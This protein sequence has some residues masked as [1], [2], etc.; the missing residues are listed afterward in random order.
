MLIDGNNAWDETHGENRKNNATQ[1]TKK[2]LYPTCI[3]MLLQNDKMP[4]PPFPSRSSTSK[5]GGDEPSSN[6]DTS[7]EEVSPSSDEESHQ[8]AITHQTQGADPESAIDP[9]FPTDCQRAISLMQE[10]NFSSAAVILQHAL[11][12]WNRRIAVVD[13][14]GVLEPTVR[15]VEVETSDGQTPIATSESSS[16]S[17]PSSD[18]RTVTTLVVEETSTPE[19]DGLSP[20]ALNISSSIHVVPIPHASSNIVK[21]DLMSSCD[22]AF[23]IFDHAF[24]VSR[25]L[26]VHG[27]FRRVDTENDDLATISATLLYNL[28]FSFH[29]NGMAK[30]IMRHL[31]IALQVYE[32][33][34]S[35]MDPSTMGSNPLFTDFSSTSS[36]H[37]EKKTLL[38][39]FAINM[40]HIN[41]LLC[42]VQQVQRARFLLTQIMCSSPPPEAS[43]STSRTSSDQGDDRD[44]DLEGSDDLNDAEQ[45]ARPFVERVIS[46]VYKMFYVS[47][48][49]FLP[50]SNTAPA[51]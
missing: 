35:M 10:N 12:D 34:L 51:A 43:S 8:P 1:K 50:A 49:L 15:Q 29:R 26:D 33:G 18:G 7:T 45:D 23:E 46:N 48:A 14:S 27:L 32:K 20:A 47:V 25:D 13:D 31:K 4:G 40:G 17:N 28:G 24:E 44:R 38:L 5:T 22:G 42:D 3:C 39:A 21:I 37:M 41:A 16:P 9:S 6:T 19:E 11:R 30:G 36:N 2:S